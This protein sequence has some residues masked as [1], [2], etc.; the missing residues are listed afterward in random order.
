MREGAV[1]YLAPEDVRLRV[2]FDEVVGAP[3]DGFQGVRELAGALQV[4]AVLDHVPRQHGDGERHRQP[5]L[6]IVARVVVPA[7]EVNLQQNAKCTWMVGR[8]KTLKPRVSRFRQMWCGL[9]YVLR[10]AVAHAGVAP[11]GDALRGRQLPRPLRLEE[12]ERLLQRVSVVQDV[13]LHAPIDSLQERVRAHQHH[14]PAH[15]LHE[16]HRDVPPPPRA[17]P[18]PLPPPAPPRP[19]H[20]QK[21][22]RTTPP[23]EPAPLRPPR[24]PLVQ[25]HRRMRSLTTPGASPT[26]IPDDRVSQPVT[27]QVL[28]ALWNQRLQ[29]GAVHAPAARQRVQ[30]WISTPSP[31]RV[32]KCA[33]DVCMYGWT[34]V[35]DHRND[36]WFEG[37]SS[38]PVKRVIGA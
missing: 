37:F 10:E 31:R 27:P 11:P 24:L 3:L 2:R 16:R 25:L 8:T 23:R 36:R 28:Q 1:P 19:H 18:L 32:F 26:C 6:D 7:R 34:C 20:Q 21:L 17:L 33:I 30:R 5:V 13:R 12:L 9:T 14:P 29:A 35:S 15:D 4:V 22:Q 38:L